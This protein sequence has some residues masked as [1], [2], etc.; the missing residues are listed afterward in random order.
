MKLALLF[1]LA[2]CATVHD[3]F[4]TAHNDSLRSQASKDLIC[5]PEQVK[6]TE[7]DADDNLWRAEGCERT[8]RYKLMNPKCLVERDCLWEKTQ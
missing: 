3:T 2:S 7:T 8:Q 5:A 4:H 1:L 6:L